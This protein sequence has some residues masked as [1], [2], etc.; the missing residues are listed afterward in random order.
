LYAGIKLMHILAVLNQIKITKT[1][2]NFSKTIASFSMSLLAVG[3]MAQTPAGYSP[4]QTP[5]NA[6]LIKT[7]QNSV[8]QKHKVSLTPVNGLL[9]YV[10]GDQ[11]NNTYSFWNGNSGDYTRWSP[12]MYMNAAYTA[13]DTVYSPLSQQNFAKANQYTANSCTVVYDTI[14]DN[15]QFALG[16]SGFNQPAP[17]SVSIDTIWTELGYHNTSGKNDTL[18]LTVCGV[19]ATG[20]PSTSPVYATLT[21]VVRPHMGDTL[22]G[23]SM[24]SIFFV[25]WI[26]KVPIVIPITAHGG[27]HFCVNATVKGSKKDT[28]GLAYYS[29]FTQCNGAAYCDSTTSMGPRN[30]SAPHVNSFLSGLYWFNSKAFK[31]NGSSVTFPVSSGSHQGSWVNSGGEQFF[32]F[33]PNGCAGFIWYPYVQNLAILCSFTYENI[34]G[35]NSISE[36]GLSV[37]QNYPNPFNKQTTINYSLTKATYVTFTVYDITGRVVTT[38]NYGNVAPGQYQINLN[39]NTFSPGVYFYTFN[40]GGS[41]VTKKM[42]ITQ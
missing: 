19:T 26:P 33:T 36:N 20:M 40:V 16:N 18:I 22:P 13:A 12:V 27:W 21:E 24:D 7:S 14:W 30:G 15:Y 31:G 28:L 29:A 3:A 8:N 1:M 6:V 34:T 5:S 11:E 25:P 35:I 38:N 37:A 23:T 41:M 32:G 42:V 17:G 10:D 4:K 39:A 9:D 2:K